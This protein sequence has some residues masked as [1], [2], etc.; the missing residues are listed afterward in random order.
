M[1]PFTKEDLFNHLALLGVQPGDNLL[2]H[3]GMFAFGPFVDGEEGLYGALL[4][5][6]GEESTIAVPTFTL[7]L[8]PGEVYTLNT[9]SQ[10]MGQFAEFIRSRP[11][12]VRSRCPMH[13]HA[14]IGPKAALLNSFSGHF[15]TGPGSDFEM[16]YSENFKNLFLGCSP[17]ESGTFLIHAEAMA[18][19]PY[20][21]WIDIERPTQWKN[22]AE[23]TFRLKYYARRQ[24][25][26]KFGGDSIGVSVD[27]GVLQK[28]LL[29]H[30]IL[31]EEKLPLGRS[32]FGS[33]K[34]IQNCVVTALTQNPYM[35]LVKDEKH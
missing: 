29:E 13:N 32:Y 10:R 26:S 16:F 5:Y 27:L 1:T 21:E 12:A 24:N 4:E 35:T 11:G 31:T 9:P 17:K 23:S 25:L 7:W 15:S 28:L 6:L 3:C 8:E 34:E 33:I 14:A 18:Q 30:K 19:A 20:R 22:E 2:I